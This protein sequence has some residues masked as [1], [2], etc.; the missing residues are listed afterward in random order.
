MDTTS[1]IQINSND[2]DTQDHDE[3]LS[4]WDFDKE[5]DELK[6]DYIETGAKE[7]GECVDSL[8]PKHLRY[9]CFHNVAIGGA[10]WED[11]HIVED[12]FCD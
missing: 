10:T 6:Q 5:L 3:D 9:S 8:P 7:M 12:L 2:E 4:S 11:H 1:P